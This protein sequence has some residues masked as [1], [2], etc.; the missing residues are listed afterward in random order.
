MFRVDAYLLTVE[1]ASP[2]IWLVEHAPP[3]SERC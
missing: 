3:L 2:A 1:R